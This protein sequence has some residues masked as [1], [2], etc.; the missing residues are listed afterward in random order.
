V[1]LR[2]CTVCGSLS[3]KTRCPAHRHRDRRPS[4]AKRG[5]D[6]RWRQTR[7][8]FLRDHPSCASCGAPAVDVH[9][10]DGLGPRGPLGH[11]PHNLQA[12]CKPC[13]GRVTAREQPGG[14][15]TTKENPQ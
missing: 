13:H 9:H 7:A 4:A 15:N 12:L 14:W 1:I 11:D 3:D 5:Y 2:A 8:R 6:H 10:L